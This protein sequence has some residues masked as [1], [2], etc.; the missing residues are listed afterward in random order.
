MVV[1]VKKYCFWLSKIM[2]M[3]KPIRDLA[4]SLL[5]SENGIHIDCYYKLEVLLKEERNN[6]D[7]IDATK[8][9]DDYIYLPEWFNDET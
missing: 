3:N 5:K 8:C 9:V 2:S 7:I 4:L 1:L 6:D